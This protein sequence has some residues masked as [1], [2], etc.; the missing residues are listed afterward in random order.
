M[1]IDEVYLQLLGD[2]PSKALFPGFCHT[3]QTVLDSASPTSCCIQHQIQEVPSG[4]KHSSKETPFSLNVSVKPIVT[5]INTKHHIGSPPTYVRHTSGE[6]KLS[7]RGTQRA[8]RGL[9]RSL[10]HVCKMEINGEIVNI[11]STTSVQPYSQFWRFL[12]A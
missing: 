5:L 10:P 9:A 2:P 3:C 6:A 4:L 11:N 7:A 12:F 1:Q 8:R